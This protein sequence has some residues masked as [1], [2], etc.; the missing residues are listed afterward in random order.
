MSK[1]RQLPEQ[2]QRMETGPI[3]FGEDWPGIFIRGD[4][5]FGYIMDLRSIKES[6]PTN[7]FNH[8]H[9]DHLINLLASC[10]SFMEA[11]L[12]EPRTKELK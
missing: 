2:K 4:N 6:L 9:I 8:L 11:E 7:D 5:A 1:I 12:T 10:Q 3:Q